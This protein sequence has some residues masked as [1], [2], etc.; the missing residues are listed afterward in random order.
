MIYHFLMIYHN[1]SSRF[2]IFD[3]VSL[4]VGEVV[5][6]FESEQPR[7]LIKLL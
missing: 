2:E 4:K 3:D 6:L 1:N 5:I 7:Q